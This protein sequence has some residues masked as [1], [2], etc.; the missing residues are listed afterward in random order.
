MLMPTR[1]LSFGLGERFDRAV[2]SFVIGFVLLAIDL[3]ERRAFT[4]GG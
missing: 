2:M 1:P 4:K 3:A